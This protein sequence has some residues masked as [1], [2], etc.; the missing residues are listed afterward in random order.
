MANQTHWKMV[1][2]SEFD[3]FVSNA[4]CEWIEVCWKLN[5]CVCVR[6]ILINTHEDRSCRRAHTEHIKRNHIHIILLALSSNEE[7]KKK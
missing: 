6:F 4:I 5:I 1:E 3:W 7:K 2:H